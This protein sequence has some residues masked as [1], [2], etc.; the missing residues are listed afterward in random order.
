MQAE[1]DSLHGDT[2]SPNAWIKV[3]V[4][5]T[6]KIGQ[7]LGTGELAEVDGKRRWERVRAGLEQQKESKDNGMELEMDCGSSCWSGWVT[8][9]HCYDE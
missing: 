6:H 4:E 9:C 7:R 8:S 1:T 5:A 2:G 3:E